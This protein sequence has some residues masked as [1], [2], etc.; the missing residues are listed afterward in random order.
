MK[1]LLIALLC[2]TALA[3][4]S[5]KY[6]ISTNGGQLIATDGR[7]KLDPDSGMYIFEDTEGREQAIPA[8]SVKQ[9][10]ER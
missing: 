10:I 3:G 4:C 2:A 1:Q 9:V 5:S 6:L 7:P 8:T